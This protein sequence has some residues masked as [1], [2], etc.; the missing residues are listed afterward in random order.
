MFFMKNIFTFKNLGI[1]SLIYTI[2]TIIVSLINILK[3]QAYDP[4]GYWREID[5]AII[6]LLLFI[7][8]YTI[9]HFHF[10]S[11]L[12]SM[13]G[14]LLPLL[15]A[16]LGYMTMLHFRGFIP[17]DLFKKILFFALLAFFGFFLL[18]WLINTFLN[19]IDSLSN[20]KSLNKLRFEFLGLL[21]IILLI[22]PFIFY[23]FFK[24]SPSFIKIYTNNL[25]YII[26]FI[27]FCILSLGIILTTKRK[28]KTG[29]AEYIMMIIY[30]IFFIL[31]Y[32]D[33]INIYLVL[34]LQLFGLM[35][36]IIYSL[37][38]KYSFN[39]ALCI[40][41]YLIMILYALKYFT[42]FLG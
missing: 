5:R 22:L 30:Y 25:F 17:F 14:Q 20:S 33:F 16:L 26:I 8:F 4:M 6:L 28:N 12:T 9:K 29:Y 36:I 7:L 18:K 39:V 31:I 13:L 34:L 19:L 3:G 40:L 35:A 38:N 27:L 24:E 1:Y 15:L 11:N 21:L 32:F 42:D 10:S 2:I 23:F 41:I 37:R